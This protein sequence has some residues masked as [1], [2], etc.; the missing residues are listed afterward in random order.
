[1]PTRNINSDLK[2]NADLT[3]PSLSTY[4]GSD[5]TALMIAGA[6]VVGKRALGTNAFNSTSFLPLAGGTMTGNLTMGSNSV[7]FDSNNS[8]SNSFIKSGGA[9][10]VMLD[11][12]NNTTNSAFVVEKDSQT[13]G[14]GTELFR[15]QEDGNVGIGDPTPT[16]KLEVNSGDTNTIA[17][18][19]SNDNRAFIRIQ[20]NDT[21]TYLISENGRFHIGGASDDLSKFNVNI[22]SGNVG[23]GTTSPNAKLELVGKQMITTGANASPQTEDYLYIGG[24]GLAGTD[25]AIYI[26]NRGNGSGYGWRMFYEGTGSGNNNK[27]KF[28]SENLGSPVDVITMLQDGNVGIGTTNPDEKLHVGGDIRVGNGGSSE[29]NHVNFTR[30]GG[31]NVGAIGWHSDNR[32]YIGGHPSFGSTAGNDVRVYGFG[33]DLHLGDNSNGDFPI[34]SMASEATNRWQ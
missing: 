15:V 21:N 27:L 26:G 29:Y 20:D 4:S 18:F 31:S 16:A 5:V 10:N 7:V 23:I 9:L 34:P 13:S 30:A 14:S 12:N 3:L 28:K 1:M 32:F 6:D 22:T 25:A 17:I 24:D 33:S 11:S 8:L 2:V 19:K